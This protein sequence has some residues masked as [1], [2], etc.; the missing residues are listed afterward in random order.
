MPHQKKPRLLDD[1]CA[2]AGDLSTDVLANVLGYL[3]VKEIMPKRRV[4]KKWK[5][6]AKKTIVPTSNNFNYFR[7]NNLKSCNAMRVMTTELPN[8]QQIAICGLWEYE[9]KWSDGE[10]PNEGLAARTAHYTTHDIGIISNFRKLR[11][12]E[13]DHDSTKL[14]GRYPVLINFPL[15]QELKINDCDN[16]KLDL[17][18]LTGLPLLKEL[19]CIGNDGLTGNISSLRVLK[20]TLETV[21]ICFCKNVEG[22]F[23]DLADFPHLKQLDLEG[24]AVTGD[25][26][27]ICVNDFSSLAELALPKEVYGGHWYELHRI[28]DAPDLIR[29]VYL[30]KKQRPALELGN[31]N[32][33]LSEDSPDWYRSIGI[34]HPP[35]QVVFVQAGPRIGYR[36]V[37]ECGKPC[38]ANWL[39][40]VPGRESDGYEEYTEK[41]QEIESQVKMYKGFFQP[42][43]EEEYGRRNQE[44]YWG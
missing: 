7:V 19:V 5:E 27:D 41:L 2:S 25:I 43:P 16:L 28:S 34:D 24:T 15:L 3:G 23:M 32:G 36:W 13:I 40:P 22:N 39:D 11:R 30:L 10:D 44:F 20:D 4:C 8:L 31:W 21:W 33:I 29:S 18:M 35:F 42:P 26:Q 9:H 12:L 1:R 14:N 6:A 38:E 17:E 37:T